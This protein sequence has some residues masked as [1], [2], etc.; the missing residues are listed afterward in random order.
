MGVGLLEFGDPFRPLPQ[1]V[2]LLRGQV[3]ET[4]LRASRLEVRAV[5]AARTGAGRPPDEEA[6]GRREDHAESEQESA[7]SSSMITAVP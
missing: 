3:D 1:D 5:V 2:D 4:P 7:H 6:G